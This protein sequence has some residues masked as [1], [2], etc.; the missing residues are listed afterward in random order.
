MEGVGYPEGGE[1]YDGNLA[2]EIEPPKRGELVKSLVFKGR[3][4]LEDRP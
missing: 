2:E 4:S 3:E 1:R